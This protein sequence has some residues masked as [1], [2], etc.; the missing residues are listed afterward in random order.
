MSADIDDTA[1]ASERTGKRA[2]ADVRRR[3][4]SAFDHTSGELRTFLAD[5]EDLVKKVADSG[6]ADLEQL[7]SRVADAIGGVRQ[8]VGI[9]NTLR[10]RVR[11]AAAR[12]DDYV[13]DR[14]WTAI[15]LAAAVGVIAGMGAAVAS[16]RQDPLR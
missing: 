7:G 12:T 5:V 14:P 4:R 9:A 11:L 2:A 1:N 13:C 6:D 15:G 3:G 16:R 10:E 8:A